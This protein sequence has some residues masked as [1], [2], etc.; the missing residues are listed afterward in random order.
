MTAEEIATERLI[1]AALMKAVSEQST[2]LIGEL[3]HEVK[4][5]FNEMISRVDRFVN[6]I[7]KNLNEAQMEYLQS[8][9][10]IYHNMNLEIR[11]NL[12]KK[13]AAVECGSCKKA[14]R[15]RDEGIKMVGPLAYDV[16]DK[17][18]SHR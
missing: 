13:Y 8:I 4:R 11:A 3:R 9:T 17:C 2:Y 15:N 16:P 6:G 14:K 5:D 10:D 18:E 7:E 12:N 1:L